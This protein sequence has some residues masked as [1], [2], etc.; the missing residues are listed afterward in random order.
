M[1]LEAGTDGQFR[2]RGRSGVTEASRERCCSII[3]QDRVSRHGHMHGRAETRRPRPRRHNSKVAL[4]ASARVLIEPFK[5]PSFQQPAEQIHI[6]QIT[7]K[8]VIV[9]HIALHMLH[10]Q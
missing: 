8:I 2:A 5:S 3:V 1:A 10:I 7:H 6:W 4:S 9:I